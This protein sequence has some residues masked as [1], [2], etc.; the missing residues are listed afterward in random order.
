VEAGRTVLVGII[1]HSM[2][3]YKPRGA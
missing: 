1:I 2:M 3:G